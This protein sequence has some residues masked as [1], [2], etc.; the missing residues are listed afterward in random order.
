MDRLNDCDEPILFTV[1]TFIPVDDTDR[2]LKIR[3]CTIDTAD[4]ALN[5]LTGIP[6]NLKVGNPPIENKTGTQPAPQHASHIARRADFIDSVTKP[7]VCHGESK[8]NATVELLSWKSKTSSGNGARIFTSLRNSQN[9][10]EDEINSGET[11]I[12]GYFKGTL[13]GIYIGSQL[14]NKGIATGFIQ[15]VIDRL[16]TSNS[17]PYTKRTLAQVCG[18]GLHSN[19]H[20]GV[21][22][23]PEGDLAWAQRAVRSWAE[24]RCVNE[25][26]S[27]AFESSI[28]S[29]SIIASD[30]GDSVKARSTSTG[31]H[32]RQAQA[33]HGDTMQSIASKCNISTRELRKLNDLSA[34]W[35]PYPYHWVCCS[36]DQHSRRDVPKPQFDG[37]C[38]SHDIKNDETCSKIA[39]AY[40]ITTQEIYD[41]NKET[42]A[43]A[44]CK[45]ILPGQRIC[46]SP[47]TPQLPTV[48]PD[49]ECGPTK[50]GTISPAVDENIGD[51]NPCPIKACCHVWG[52][53]GVDQ[54]F[55]VATNSETGNPGTAAPNTNGCVQNC[56][57]DIVQSGE[58]PA[59]FMKVGYF[60]AWDRDRPCLHMSPKQI[61]SDLTHVHYAFVNINSSF[62]LDLGRF[63]DVFE[64][65]KALQ[66]PERIIAIGGWAFS[67][68]PETYMLFRNAIKPENRDKFAKAC[69]RFVTSHGLDGID[70]D[71][72]YP[73]QPDIEGI[74]PGD[75]EE[76]QNYL[77][78]IKIVKSEMDTVWLSRRELS[79]LSYQHDRNSFCTG[80]GH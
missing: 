18:T 47:G 17:V 51:L 7:P 52:H 25:S 78:F 74:P 73:A 59:S 34:D 46:V 24:A 11:V 57:M 14:Q 72:E 42:W 66:G 29:A 44:G 4:S 79:S 32:C 21:V 12:Y 45:G 20:V 10:L 58:V 27:S 2:Q 55:C 70:F 64:E 67:T 60:E 33:A 77:D 61:P 69:V 31:G 9:F 40:G 8:T 15:D 16:P 37:T 76:S 36:S 23:D 1:S 22:I 54:D 28:S 38:A 5:A 35:K 43:W 49:A 6:P 53:C 75:A 62:E 19:S 65:F 13:V 63:A 80:H 68:E 30:S 39:S 50:G 48:N 26:S 71:W 3:D 41:Y 56:G